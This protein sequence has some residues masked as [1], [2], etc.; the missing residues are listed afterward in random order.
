MIYS[1]Q[2]FIRCFVFFFSLR[3][4]AQVE[5]L[6]HYIVEEPPM[7]AD[8]KHIFKW[9]INCLFITVR[10]L[11]PLALF[12]EFLFQ[13]RF[14][15]IASEIFTCEVDIILRTLVEDVEVV[16]S[17]NSFSCFC[18]ISILI[19]IFFNN[20]TNWACH[21]F[22]FAAAVGFIILLHQARSIAQ[23]IARWLLQ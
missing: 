12:V 19:L 7:D 23:Y 16:T 17:I 11:L 10:F 3:E 1:C 6:L 2:L 5:K 9:A 13:C 8:Q 22:L 15:F 21:C 20:A 4:K 14:P 18:F